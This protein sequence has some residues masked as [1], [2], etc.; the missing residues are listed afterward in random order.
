MENTEELESWLFRL[1]NDAK[2][3]LCISDRTIAYILLREGIN[4]YLKGLTENGIRDTKE[5][6]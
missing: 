6:N 4:Y 3:K 5:H 2:R 1:L